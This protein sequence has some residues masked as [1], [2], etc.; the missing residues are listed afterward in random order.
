MMEGALESLL[1]AGHGDLMLLASLFAASLILED[2]ATIGGGVLAAA[3][4]VDPFAA[5]CVLV[6]GTSVGDLS[7]HFMGRWFARHRWVVAHRASPRFAHASQ[8]LARWDWMLLAAARC[9]PGLRL[10]VY[11]ASGVTKLPVRRSA[12]TILVAGSLWTP[13]LF[14]AAH[15]G[16]CLATSRSVPL[17]S[18]IAPV[19]VLAAGAVAR[20]FRASKTL[21]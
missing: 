17:L 18:I 4:A 9:I 20:L 15:F 5:V 10:P 11:L 14:G 7:L 2:A 19:I 3:G 1:I 21:N 13:A 6:L 12:A 16:G 8:L